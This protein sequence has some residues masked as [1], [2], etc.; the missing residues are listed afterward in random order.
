MIKSPSCNQSIIMNSRRV[1]R[2]VLPAAPVDVTLN[3]RRRCKRSND[4]PA[5]A[6][7]EIVRDDGKSQLGQQ[8]TF[9]FS[10]PFIDPGLN[11]EGGMGFVMS[12][13]KAEQKQHE[14]DPLGHMHT[15]GDTRETHDP[16]D[17]SNASL[18]PSSEQKIDENAKDNN[19]LKYGSDLSVY[20]R[21]NNWRIWASKSRYRSEISHQLIR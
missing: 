14:N 9:T 2:M 1:S 21:W 17:L 5:N 12:R 6:T 4:R 8:I 20:N 18:K 13:N 15:P 11:Q 3:A 7:F 16:Q 19:P 10:Y